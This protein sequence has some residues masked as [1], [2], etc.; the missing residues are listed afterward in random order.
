MRIVQISDTHLAEGYAA[1]DANFDAAAAWIRAAAPDLVV[2]TGDITRDAPG[3]PGELAYAKAR[4]QAL[5]VPVL[6]LPGNHDIGDNPADG[7]DPET[8]VSDALLQAYSAVFGPDRWVEEQG[9]WRI[10]G[11]N[12]LLCQSGLAAEAAQ[13]AW[14]E[15]ALAGHDRIALFLHKPLFLEPDATPEDPPYRY[16][17]QG[18]RA[19]LAA[20]IAGG[21]VRVVGCGHVHQ[22][23]AHR[24][25][26]A[27]FVW[28]PA[29][30][31][32]LPDTMQPRIGEKV[33]GLVAYTLGA[34]GSVAY[35]VVRPE[36]I[37]DQDLTQLPKAY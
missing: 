33:C 30:A 26:Q 2:H 24:V 22:T 1:F 8:P 20:L 37:A 14:L 21:G 31:F 9:G 7:Y 36:G 5:G 4:L 25:G 12:S 11:M 18:P 32:V 6:A 13:W 17:P 10:V 29:T 27:Q 15:E 34:D 28:A 16:V 35:E 19:R 23:R 3:A